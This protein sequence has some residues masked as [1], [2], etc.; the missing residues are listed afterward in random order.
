M[1]V[2]IRKE[3]NAPTRCR[4]E[5]TYRMMARFCG[6]TPSA[7]QA[8]RMMESQIVNNH[9]SR[10]FFNFLNQPARTMVVNAPAMYTYH[11]STGDPFVYH[12][13][14][15]A[16]QAEIN[17]MTNTLGRHDRTYPD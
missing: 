15:K 6:R 9:L 14:A 1:S 11:G 13:D 2:A 16:S 4:H 8:T 17:A 12:I 10:F 7:R 3:R 5:R